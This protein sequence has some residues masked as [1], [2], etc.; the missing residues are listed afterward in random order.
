MKR[1]AQIQ[2]DT[3]LAGIAGVLLITMAVFL[4]L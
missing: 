2:A 4:S 3:L 1:I